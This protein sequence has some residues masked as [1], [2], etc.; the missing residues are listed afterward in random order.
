MCA[1]QLFVSSRQR[2][3]RADDDFNADHAAGYEIPRRADPP[4]PESRDGRR[5]HGGARA[6]ALGAGE[7]E[8][9]R[10]RVGGGRLAAREARPAHGVA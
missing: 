5:R 8:D 10:H 3:S 9:G 7:G 4:P 2:G 1:G 6:H